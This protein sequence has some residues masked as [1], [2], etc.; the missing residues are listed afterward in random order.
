MFPMDQDTRDDF[1]PF[2]PEHLPREEDE[3]QLS[4]YLN[5]LQQFKSYSKI[6]AIMVI[7]LG[8][9]G[10]LGWFFNVPLLRGEY[11]GII[12]I[13]LNTALLFILAGSCVYLLN[14]KLKG[15]QVL[16]PRI[17]GIIIVVWGTLTILEY[18]TGTNLGMNYLFSSILPNNSILT[19]SRLASTLNFILLGVALLMASYKFKIRYVQTIAF[20]CGFIALFGLSS[21]L[22]GSSSD[23][24]LDILAQMAFMTSLIHILLSVSI[25]CLCPDH[26]YMGRITAQNSGGYMARRLLP[27]AL[28]A[29]FLMDLLIVS[30]ERLNIYSTY[31]GNILGVILALAFLTTVII[32]NSNILNKM[33]RQRQESNIRRLNL[34]KFYENLVEGINEGIW[35]TDKHDRLYFMNRGME[36]ISGVTSQQMEGLHILEDLPDNTTDGLKEYYR[37]AK[38]TLKPVHYDSIKATS[39][40]GRQSY[41][42]GWIIPQLKEGKFNGAI[43]TVIDETLRKEAENALKKSETFYRTIFENTGT[44]TIIIDQNTTIIMANK[45]C[46]SMSGYSVDEIEHQLSWTNFVH[47]DDR[48]KMKTYQQMR[49]VPGKEAPSEYEFR[50]LNKE[51]EEREVLLFTSLIP[52]TTDSV[53]SM[54]DITER[55][56]AENVIKKSLKDK[57]LLLREIHHRVKNNMQI[58]SS[59]L[60]L[61]RSYVDDEEAD[62]ILQESQGRV[63]SMALVHEK[64][65]QTADLAKINVGDYI[66]SLTMNLFHSYRTKPGIRLNLDVG[67]IYFN[68]DTAIPLGLIINELVSNCLKYAFKD[69]NEGEVVISVRKVDMDELDE[70]NEV[71]GIGGGNYYLLEV[72]DD[73]VGLPEDLDI[74]HTNTLGLQ[75]VKTLVLQLDGTIKII[76]N[77]GTCFHIIFQEQKYIKR[78]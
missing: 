41:Q 62:N 23:Y 19:K 64:L 20:F 46:E 47:P 45:R 21:Y 22:Y 77:N 66:E 8:A 78:I 71:N 24:F 14:L 69:Q 9:M 12:G 5:R 74:E 6:L 57:E 52:G 53:V 35:V 40:S 33:D 48:E 68:I 15:K 67:D 73:G 32:W 3:K 70:V 72:R 76:R 49:R 29:V 18:I 55:K 75:L 43:C 16:I 4:I 58:I 28:M 51:G 42:S 65:Y 10:A 56:K 61:Q 60:N 30:G 37:K 2:K 25:L 34:K 13:K 26:S 17:L 7:I 38:E 50:L 39:P 36:E 1:E 59:L 27:A 54:L 44:A 11:E 31:F 63:K